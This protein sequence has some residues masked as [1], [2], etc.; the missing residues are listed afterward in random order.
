VKLAKGGLHQQQALLHSV[1]HAFSPPQMWRE[2][3]KCGN[4]LWSTMAGNKQNLH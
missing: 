4:W 1:Q 3:D 2:Y